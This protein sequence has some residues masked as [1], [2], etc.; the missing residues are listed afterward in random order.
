MT[1]ENKN[2]MNLPAPTLKTEG[3]TTGAASDAQATANRAR[4]ERAVEDCLAFMVKYKRAPE[5]EWVL[6]EMGQFIA[7]QNER[8]EA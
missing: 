2:T 6:D 3:V 7:S 8:K 4:L 5:L 1:T